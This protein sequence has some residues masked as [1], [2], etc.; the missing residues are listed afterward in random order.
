MH[1]K[2]NNQNLDW[3]SKFRQDLIM[4]QEGFCALCGEGF[5]SNRLSHLDHNHSN[6]QIRE[7]ICMECNIGLGKFEESIE[8]LEK[9]IKYLKKH[10]QIWEE[11]PSLC[12]LWNE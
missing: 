8:K 10:Q 5:T 4:E 6:N 7:V 9:A 3:R 12:C 11:N 2:F 1:G